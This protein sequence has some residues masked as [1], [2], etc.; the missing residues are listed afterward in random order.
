MTTLPAPMTDREPIVTPGQMIAPPPT[1]TSEPISMG[2]A[3]SC[4]R[5]KFG[6]DGMR[7]G[8]DLDG[9]TEQREVADAHRA[10][11]ED[12]AVEVEEDALA[13]Q[14]VRA[15]VAEEGRLHPDFTAAAPNSSTR[16]RRRVSSSLSR[17]AFRS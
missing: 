11:V 9:R 7:G 15:V 13:E 5:R 6:F 8:V 10:H 14:D 3:N 2:L 12:D 17:V 16:M 4:L 1:H